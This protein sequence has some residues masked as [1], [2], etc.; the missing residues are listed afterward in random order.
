LEAPRVTIGAA[1]NADGDSA[2]G[3]DRGGGRLAVSFC[4]D[5]YRIF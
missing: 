3:M 2:M 1:I 4:F 5:D